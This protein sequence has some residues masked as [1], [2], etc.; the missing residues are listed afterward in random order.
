[1]IIR[2]A[3]LED[4]KELV[5]LNNSWY[6]DNLNELE[7]GFLSVTY[8]SDFFESI[9]K[10]EDILVFTFDGEIVGYIL[11]N[12]IYISDRIKNIKAEYYEIRNE[13][14]TKKVA[15][16][17]Q[18]LIDRIVQGKGYFHEAQKEY[19]NYIK[20]KYEVLVSTVSKENIRS[21]AAHKK[22]G[23]NFIDTP[24]NYY[25]IEQHI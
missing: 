7:N 14:F 13:N 6:R 4:T 19:L 1:M 2:P 12:D 24:K 8:G 20:K 9:I 25:I 21:I 22:A 17:Y 11:V 5:A 3:T 10:N 18:I 16:G 23:W 15:F